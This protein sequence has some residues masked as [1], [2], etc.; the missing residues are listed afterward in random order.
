MKLDEEEPRKEPLRIKNPE[1]SVMIQKFMGVSYI[2]HK[3]ER[4]E[5]KPFLWQQ[6]FE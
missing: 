5:K 3:Y 1:D 2:N 6:F 4:A